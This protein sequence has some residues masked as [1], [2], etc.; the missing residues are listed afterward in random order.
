MQWLTYYWW[1]ALP[2][3]R[4]GGLIINRA[5]L[6]MK[7]HQRMTI[8][9]QPSTI[10]PESKVKAHSHRAKYCFRHNA[11]F[12]TFWNYLLSGVSLRMYR[13]QHYVNLKDAILTSQAMT[14]QFG[15][16][17]SQFKVLSVTQRA[18]AGGNTATIVIGTYGIRQS[19]LCTVTVVYKNIHLGDLTLCNE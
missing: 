12:Y 10:S 4:V 7:T 9:V 5:Y 18:R 15:S 11:D 13:N 1:S 19:W 14:I 6:N 16:R 3:S 17:L 8:Q 2:A